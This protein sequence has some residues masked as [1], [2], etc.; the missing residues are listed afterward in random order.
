M[1]AFLFFL[2]FVTL[3]S[4]ASMLGWV[5]DSRDGSGWAPTENGRPVSRRIG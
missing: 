1:A 3:L 4:I 2:T 5:A